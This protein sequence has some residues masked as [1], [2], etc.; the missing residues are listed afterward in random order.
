MMDIASVTVGFL[1]LLGA[2]TLGL[3]IATVMFG[4]G[5]IGAALYLGWPGA[6]AMIVVYLGSMDEAVLLQLPL[7]ILLGEILVR[8]GATDRMYHSLTDWLNPLPGGL[9]HT[10]VATAAT[11]SAVALPSFKKK[12]YDTRMVLGSIAAG[13]SLGNLIPPGIAF[14]IYGVLTNTSVA[15]LYAGGVFPGALLTVMFMATI[16]L[17]TWWWPAIAPREINSDPMLAKVKRLV[18]LLPP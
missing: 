6:N 8:C 9:L 15:R 16:I 12:S 7:F 3:H 2:M 5:F 14:I 13:G 1:I 4:V 18:D 17:L 10:N 11:I